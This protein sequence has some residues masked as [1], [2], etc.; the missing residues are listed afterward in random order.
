MSTELDLSAWPPQAQVGLRLYQ[1]GDY[2]AAH[3]ALED[4]WRAATDPVAR[5]GLQGL[6]QLAVACLHAQRGNTAGAVK[7]AR[8]ALKHL[9]ATPWHWRGL[10][11]A[12]LRAALALWLAD[13]RQGRVPNACPRLRA[14][15]SSSPPRSPSSPRVRSFV[16][17]E[18]R[19]TPA[20]QRALATWGPR[21]LLPLEQVL[22][23]ARVFGRRAALILDIGFGDGQALATYAQAHPEMDFIGTEVYRPGVGALLQRLAQAGI[24]N[25]RVFM[26]D[27]WEVLTRAIPDA[28]LAGVQIFF[29]DPWPKRRHRKRRLIQPAFADLLARKL[30]PGGWL[31]LAT[32]WPDYAAHMAAVLD[33]HPAFRNANP[34]GGP[35]PP[36]RRRRPTT[37]F[38]RKALAEGR[39]ATDFLYWRRPS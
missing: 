13:L 3:E 37:K 29:P 15:P 32:D 39:V 10:D 1:Q 6:T 9:A 19:L 20:Q 34:R 27:A 17:R 4:A 36:A 25:V 12:H 7:V 11:M 35:Y 23:P 28:S 24:D 30:Q 26:A 21:Y 31:H 2:F 38:E 18:G 33:T 16:L 14:A 8:R 22:D 5:E